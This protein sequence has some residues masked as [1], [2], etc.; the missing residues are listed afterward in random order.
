MSEEPYLISIVTPVYNAAAYIFE[1]AESVLSQTYKNWEWILVDDC[2]ADESYMLLRQLAERD[3]R[4]H[5]FR[6]QQNSKAFATRNNCLKRVKGTFIAFLDAD[7]LWATHK[8]QSQ[9]RFML[10]HQHAITYTAFKRFVASPGESV[11]D[12]NVPM[13]AT[14]S[15]IICNN[16]IATSTVMI[17]VRLTGTFTMQNVYYDDFTLWLELLRRV[18]MAF[19]LNEFLMFYRLSENS[20]SRNK[21]KSAVKVYEMFTKKMNFGF[22]KSRIL[23]IRWVINT[24]KRY[25]FE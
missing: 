23:F 9:L 4:I 14:Y 10:A 25:L 20:L 5:V 24:T 11:K 18:Q 15:S 19:G 17:D 7:D 3:P 22:F 8:L 2:S 13:T 1:T 12:V 6:N 16:Y 21:I